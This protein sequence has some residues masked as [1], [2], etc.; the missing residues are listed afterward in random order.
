M[1]IKGVFF[2]AGDLGELRRHVGGSRGMQSPRDRGRM[3]PARSKCLI[4][5]QRASATQI[6]RAFLPGSHF[7]LIGGVRGTIYRQ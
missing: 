5:V 6:Q 3:F 7:R 4:R 1:C 2:S